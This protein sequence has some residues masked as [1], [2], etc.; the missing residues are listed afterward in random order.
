MRSGE[1]RGVDTEQEDSSDP[2]SPASPPQPTHLPK[3]ATPNL[4][5]VAE[6]LAA[7]A[8]GGGHV[9][10]G[11][12]GKAP[13]PLPPSR[14]PPTHPKSVGTGV[15][16][17][18]T[19]FS[20]AATHIPCQN[21]SFLIGCSQDSSIQSVLPFGIPSSYDVISASHWLPLRLCSMLISPLLAPQ[22]SPN[23][24]LD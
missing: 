16:A 9:W 3:P 24:V 12:E 15:R 23:L 7:K 13:E 11:Q 22:E 2:W 10:G 6:V 8:Q 20:L 4:L 19:L 14:V 18:I 17:D 5:Q 21:L 1:S